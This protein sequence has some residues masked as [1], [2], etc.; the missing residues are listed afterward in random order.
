MNYNNY[1]ELIRYGDLKLNI[2][3]RIPLLIWIYVIVKLLLPHFREGSRLYKHTLLWY[4]C[5][6]LGYFFI[7]LPFILSIYA[8]FEPYIY[9]NHEEKKIIWERGINACLEDISNKEKYSGELKKL[10]LKCMNINQEYIKNLT[11]DLFSK[12][13]EVGR[14]TLYLILLA[15]ASFKTKLVHENRFAITALNLAFLFGVIGSSVIIFTTAYD[16]ESLWFV[17]FGYNILTL[18]AS[19]LGLASTCLFYLTFI[20]WF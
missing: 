2:L 10:N 3:T 8:Y 11:I 17:I 19:C 1:F 13:K 12:Y 18:Y 20:K 4:F 14:A 5:R 15:F 6:V 16:I 9:S 7:I